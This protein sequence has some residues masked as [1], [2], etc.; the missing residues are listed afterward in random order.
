MIHRIK[1]FS[2]YL[3]EQT[4]TIQGKKLD[5]TVPKRAVKSSKIVFVDANKFDSMY[6][7]EEMYVG[8]KGKGG[9]KDKYNRINLFV[10]GGYEDV[11][12]GIKIPYKPF[13][14]T[15]EV[16]EV[17]VS[18]EGRISFTDGRHRF[19][20]FKDSGLKKIPVAMSKESIQNAKKFNLL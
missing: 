17:S 5:L 13:S 2:D 7:K 4:I 10:F 6:K 9:N 11:G 19:A 14:G 16:S 20:W 15:F 8:S 1:A 3:K 18:N 12:G